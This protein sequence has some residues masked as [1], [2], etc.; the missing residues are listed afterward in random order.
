M[1][2][3]DIKVG[4]AAFL[5][6]GGNPIGAVH[7]VS[8]NGR[9]EFVMYVENAG[10]FVVPFTAIKGVHFEKIVLDVARLDAELRAAIAHAHDAESP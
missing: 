6:D 3:P 10:D 5:K 1:P 2:I 4:D 8:P 9:P 7:Q